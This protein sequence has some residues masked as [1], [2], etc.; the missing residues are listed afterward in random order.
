MKHLHQ[1]CV[2]EHLLEWEQQNPYLHTWSWWWGGVQGAPCPLPRGAW[3]ALGSRTPRRGPSATVCSW[4]S[5]QCVSLPSYPWWSGTPPPSGWWAR[6]RWWS[7]RWV[8]STGTWLPQPA[9]PEGRSGWVALETK[10]NHKES[11]NPVQIPI[12]GL[13]SQAVPK[14]FKTQAQFPLSFTKSF[15]SI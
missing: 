6:P 3:A 10:T 2:A 11:E 15:I 14:P 13:C 1:G 12:V 5:P 8:W 9:A 7:W 4:E